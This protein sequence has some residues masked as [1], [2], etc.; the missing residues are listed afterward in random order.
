MIYLVDLDGTVANLDHRLHLIKK[1]GDMAVSPED[2]TAFFDACLNHEENEW[3]FVS[4]WVTSS[5]K[6]TASL[7]S[8]LAV[9]LRALDNVFSSA[10]PTG[11]PAFTE[12]EKFCGPVGNGNGMR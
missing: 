1:R 2:W 8:T 12:N 4:T 7:I 3:R 6:T 9:R 5:V 10:G 11:S